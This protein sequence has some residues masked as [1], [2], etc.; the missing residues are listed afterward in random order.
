VNKHEYNI[1]EESHHQDQVI[2][3]NEFIEG[4]HGRKESEEIIIKSPTSSLDETANLHNP[5]YL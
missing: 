2:D 1:D 4:Y 3:N 5:T